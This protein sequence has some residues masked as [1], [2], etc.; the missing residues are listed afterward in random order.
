MP[1]QTQD[2][3]RVKKPLIKKSIQ[4]EIENSTVQ[5]LQKRLENISEKYLTI[6]ERI[7]KDL[8]LVADIQQ[9]AQLIIET[10]EKKGVKVEMPK[11]EQAS[12]S[13]EET[14]QWD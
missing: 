4:K 7:A 10:L 13:G 3:G 8:S 2:N 12:S 5:Q 9:Q 6:S 11:I 14:K 1:Q